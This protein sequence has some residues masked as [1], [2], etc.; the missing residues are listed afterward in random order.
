MNKT[1]Y[2]L[3]NERR[4]LPRLP[5]ITF[6]IIFIATVGISV[7][8]AAGFG[9]AGGAALAGVG[10]AFLLCAGRGILPWISV[11]LSAGISCIVTKDIS[12]TLVS[13]IFVLFGVALAYT[14]FTKRSLTVTVAFLTVCVA[15]SMGAGLAS[16]ATE[17][18]GQGIKGSVIAFGR[19]F[20][21]LVNAAISSIG[22]M[23]RDKEIYGFSPDMIESYT[24]MIIMMLPSAMIMVCEVIAYAA[25][26][27]FQ[28]IAVKAGYGVFF[29]DKE[30]KLTLSLPSA[31]LFLLSFSAGSLFVDNPVIFYAAINIAYIIMPLAAVAGA[32]FIF[33]KGGLLRRGLPRRSLIM[34]IGTCV[35]VVILSGFSVLPM[36][37][38]LGSGAVIWKKIFEIVIARK[39]NNDDQL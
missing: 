13:L 34:F 4:E 28:L 23:G 24:E 26:R 17:L 8:S 36:L 3:W 2:P 7:L 22:Y 19:E 16:S 12:D 30:M 31:I 33:G 6:F 5:F 20:K 39:K 25:A 29:K 27:L 15:L 21:E 37:S 11:V 9:G 38:F 10:F 1:K 14:V 18:Y 32:R 35:F